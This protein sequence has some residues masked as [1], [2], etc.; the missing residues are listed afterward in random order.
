MQMKTKAILYLAIAAAAAAVTASAVNHGTPKVGGP[1]SGLNKGDMLPAYEPSHVSGADKGTN[2]CPVCKY[3]N[4]P[5]VQVWINNDNWENATKI[6]KTLDERMSKANGSATK[7]ALKAFVVFVQPS[8]SETSDSKAFAKKLSDVAE[9]N[10]FENV[11]LA[12]VPSGDAAVKGYRINL[13]TQVQNTVFVY[14]NR[15]VMA[16]FVN[17]KAD[18][19]GLANLNAAVSSIL[20]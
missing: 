14:K 15:K 16:K 11:A 5:A 17:L 10:H 12:Y 20:R 8:D 3:G 13:D 9:S 19:K 6:A 1:E 4:T 18:D 2:T 7:P